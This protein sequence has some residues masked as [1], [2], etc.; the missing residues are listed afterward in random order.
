MKF[1]FITLFPEL[2]DATLAVGVV[3]QAIKKNI[4]SY[5]LVNPRD[6]ATD[7][8]R[9]V[10]D[11]SYGGIDGMVMIAEIMQKSLDSINKDNQS[12]NKK[13][14]TFYLSP[15]G[16]TFKHEQINPLLELDE[17]TF[18]CGRYA[19]IDNRFLIHNH[20]EE[21]SLGDFVLSGGELAALVIMDAIS[22]QIP[23]VLGNA[24]SSVN[25]SFSNNLLEAP[26]FT[27]PNKWQDL[28]VPEVLMSGHHLKIE[29]WKEKMSLLVTF[30]KRP[31]LLSDFLLKKETVLVQGKKFS[32]ADLEKFYNQLSEKEKIVCGIQNMIFHP[33]DNR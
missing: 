17:V 19:G 15:Q 18:I 14:K 8:H 5:S 6:F 30:K 16:K 20:I 3:G 24:E 11:I 25:D 10:D 21:I 13:M 33:H 29:E 32:L 22:R 12:A 28:E 2:I 23:G 31:D 26:C 7:N 1:N 27:R 9:S 4:I